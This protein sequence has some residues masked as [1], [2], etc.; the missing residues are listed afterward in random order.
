VI[1]VDRERWTREVQRPDWYLRIRDEYLELLARARACPRPTARAIADEVYRFFEHALEQQ[2]ITI[3]RSG[4]NWDAQRR[5]VDTVVVH[6]TGLDPG[7]TARR[8][9]AIHLTR[10][11]ASY[12]A[13]PAPTDKGIRGTGIHSGHV[14]NGRQVFYCYHW[15]VRPDGQCER[16]L[17]DG[18]TGWHAGNWAINCRSVAICLDADLSDTPPTDS[19]LASIRQLVATHY[20]DVDFGR[21]AAHA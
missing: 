21:G 6:H 9:E 1:Y 20:P 12:Y 11:Y 4:P 16:L 17:E 5:P 13:D 8:I 18:E 7:I 14:R 3:A 10:I 2:T 19:A 15:L